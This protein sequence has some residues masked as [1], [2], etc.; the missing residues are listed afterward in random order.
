MTKTTGALKHHERS[1]HREN[2]SIFNS[3][4]EFTENDAEETN[5]IGIAYKV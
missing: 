3:K 4:S 5:R 2:L 1:N